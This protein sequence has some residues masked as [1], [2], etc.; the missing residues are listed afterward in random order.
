M[1]PVLTVVTV[2]R[3][4]LRH[5]QRQGWGLLRQDDT[6]FRWVVV[7]MGGPD[8]RDVTL[9]STLDPLV[10]D[11][12]VADD[13]PL[14]LAAARNA[15]IAASRAT[16]T[17]AGVDPVDVVV[18]LDVDVIP[19]PELVARYRDAVAR[20]RGV[21]AGPVGYLP[22]G[23]PAGPDDLARLPDHATPHPA[24]P[25]PAD[26]T[27]EP[28]QRWELLWTLSMALPT[29]LASQA[30]GFD[31]RY[32]GYG[33]EDTDFAIRLRSTGAELH[34]VGG[35]WGYHQHHDAVGRRDQVPDLVRNASLFHATWGWWP[36]A[37]WLADLQ[38]DGLVVWDPDG[39]TLRL[40]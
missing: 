33:A 30:G 32:V 2:V 13:A 25:V 31:E 23:V 7:R 3:G 9:A 8:V 18:L 26:G 6:D 11:L 10:V 40:V 22:P 21:V 14:P 16:G 27:L 4:R 1:T 34:W 39:D 12:D 19:S 38:R 37:G 15:G 17:S 35:A 20:T 5:L 36:M 29:A 24:R 28:E